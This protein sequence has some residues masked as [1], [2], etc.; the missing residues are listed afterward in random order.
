M[1][2]DRQAEVSKIAL[3]RN[4]AAYMTLDIKMSLWS[5]RP[6]FAT[7]AIVNRVHFGDIFLARSALKAYLCLRI[8]LKTML[9]CGMDRWDSIGA[10]IL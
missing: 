10:L 1:P 6:F 8:A 2:I 9:L 5:D 4:P 7:I 3:F